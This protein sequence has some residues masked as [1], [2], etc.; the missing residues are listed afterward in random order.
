MHLEFICQAGGEAWDQPENKGFDRDHIVQVLD[1]L[2]SAG[3]TCDIVNSDGL[4]EEERTKRY[5]R[6]VGGAGNRYSV[7]ALYGS[8]R[9]GGG[10]Y[11]G[12]GVPALI[13]FD[14]SEAVDVYHHEVG[15]DVQTIRGYVDSL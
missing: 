11:F 12:K 3:H 2:R 7:S 5:F 10:P 9:R 15:G 1:R 6:A 13:V 4:S 8:R 14:G